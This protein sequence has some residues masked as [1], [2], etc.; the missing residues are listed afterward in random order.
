MPDSNHEKEGS[1]AA[2]D[3]DEDT[4]QENP[5][6]YFQETLILPCDANIVRDFCVTFECSAL[7]Q[8]MGWMEM[9][10]LRP[11][12]KYSTDLYKCIMMQFILSHHMF[13]AY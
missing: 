7:C 3:C 12:E 4:V 1:D 9:W 10:Q 11:Q 6:S 5:P 8:F 2:A 13:S